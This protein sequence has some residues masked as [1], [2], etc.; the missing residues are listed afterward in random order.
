MVRGY[1]RRPE[2]TADRFVSHPFRRDPVARLY[3]TGDLVRWREDGTLEFLGRVDFQVKVR[4]YRI[5]LGEIENALASHPDVREAVVMAR[6][7]DKNGD[8]RLVG[9]VVWKQPQED[10][11]GALRE[12]LHTA[13][14]EFMMPSHLIVLRDLPRTP[15]QKIDRKAL[16]SPASIAAKEAKAI[17]PAVAPAGELETII[18]GIWQEVL[19]LPNVGVGDNFFDLGGHSLLAVQVHS[20]L[21]KALER[22]LSITD[23]FRFP[24][25]RGL[26]GFL[27]GEADG[28]AV[29]TGID[30]AAE[31]REMSA[32]RSRRST[33]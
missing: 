7:D 29:K 2:L 14:P 3:R 33:S 5:E 9:Y 1:W 11:V 28:V 15:N 27:G 30:R 31:R 25:I 10:G 17:Q 16:P 8:V 20:R 12:H 21:K 26:A 22:D 13:L 19:K 4:G 18:A 32:R 23:L 24:T 6:D